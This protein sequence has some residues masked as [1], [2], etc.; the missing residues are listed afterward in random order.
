[1]NSPNAVNIVSEAL[2]AGVMPKASLI[3]SGKQNV[4]SIKNRLRG[5]KIGC[6]K[7]NCLCAQRKKKI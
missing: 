5:I 7:A 4:D 6:A 2:R 3:K 1:M